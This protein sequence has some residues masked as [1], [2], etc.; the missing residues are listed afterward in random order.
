MI[1]DLKTGDEEGRALALERYGVLDTPEEPSFENVMDLVQQVMQVPLCGITLVDRDRLW[2]KSRRGMDMQEMP[3]KGTMSSAAIEQAEPFIVEDSHKDP[4]F[5]NNHTV[6]GDPHVRSYVG[7]PLRSPEGYNVGT[8]CVMDTISRTFPASHITILQNFAKV[9]MNELE[10]RQVASSDHL[11]GT[12]SRRAWTERAELEIERSRRYK[13]P[14]SL[15]ILDIDKFKLVNDTFG[16]S[17]GDLVIQGIADLCKKMIRKS[18]FCGR[19][20]GEEFAIMMPETELNDA[21]TVTER[22]RATFENVLIDIGAKRPVSCTVSVGVAQR[23]TTEMDLAP[24]LNRADQA[25]YQAKTTG[26]NR[27]ES[28]AA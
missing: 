18:D 15:A 22:I 7:A 6:I 9:V 27:V 13:R 3:R 23:D 20:G 24:F 8:L 14:V 2:F 1:V 25:L 19:L 10:L 26:R 5:C 28:T 12:L 21:F 11:T 17:A 4:R 16:H